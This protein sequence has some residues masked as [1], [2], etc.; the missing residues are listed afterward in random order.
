MKKI[1]SHFTALREVTLLLL[2][3]ACSFTVLFFSP[4]DIYIGNQREFSVNSKDILVPL[5]ICA[6]IGFAALAI[7]FNILLAV[8]PAVFDIG[9]NLCFG[10]LLSFYLQMLFLNGNMMA[11]TGDYKSYSLK[12]GYVKINLVITALIA[13]APLAVWI[14]KH[15]VKDNPVLNIGG[16]KAMVFLCGAMFLM[17][18]VGTVGAVS[19]Q[20]LNKYK[21]NYEKYLSYKPTMTLSSDENIIVFL[22]D[23]LDSLWMDEM[24]E[25]YPEI[26]GEFDGFTF[27]Q[28][29]VARNTNTFPS[30]P[31]MLT[32]DTY[33]GQ[34]WGDYFEEAWSGDTLPDELKKNGYNVYLLISN[35]TTY[36]DEVR[37]L[38]GKC[39]NLI[40]EEDGITVNYTGKRGVVPTMIDLSLGKLTPYCLKGT[41]VGKYNSDFDSGFL[42]FPDTEDDRLA[43]ALGVDSDIAYYA[44]LQEHGLKTGSSKPTFTFVHL[45]CS[46]DKSTKLATLHGGYDTSKEKADVYETT[47]GDFEIL[48]EYFE[49]LKEL[50]IYDNTTIIILGDHGRA[51]REIEKENDFYLTSA[52]TTGLLIKPAGSRGEIELN[53]TAEL[54]NEY[55]PA[56]VLEY[57]GADHS[58]YGISYNDVING[59]LHPERILQCYRWHTFGDMDIAARYSITGDARDFDNWVLLNPEDNP[60]QK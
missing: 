38:D 57:A 20:G 50:G 58:V 55:L 3:L 51:P 56:S 9:A 12:N 24:L 16:G 54:S 35:K 37:D 26:V 19:S 13:I 36:G 32:V 33:N 46:H 39:D 45:N 41:F 14:I 5:L 6:G 10:V 2:S 40:D 11:M 25:K 27:Y 30:V 34:E 17:Q 1:L 49:Q 4:A 29:N 15:K 7:F 60:H 23:R 43:K 44:Y 8:H 22:T 47:R 53:D 48:F 31:Q 59:D 52:I 42:N 21:R 18:A 28:N